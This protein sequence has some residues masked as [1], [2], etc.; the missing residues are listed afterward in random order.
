MTRQD[1]H[2][3]PVFDTFGL[4]VHYPDVRTLCGRFRAT[5]P[6]VRP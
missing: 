4:L 3:A 1:L 2:P 5:L 6:P